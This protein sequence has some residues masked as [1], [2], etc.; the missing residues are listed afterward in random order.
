MVLK[1]GERLR[2]PKCGGKRFNATAHVTQDWELDE[3]G[4]FKKSLN[5]C[6][7]VTHSPDHDDIWDCVKCGFSAPGR[8]FI[9]GSTEEKPARLIESRVA[10][11]VY[12]IS[13]MA[14]HMIEE[15]RIVVDD[16]RGLFNFVYER[17][18]EFETAWAKYEIEGDYMEKI[19][20]F[21]KE[22]LLDAYGRENELKPKV[23]TVSPVVIA[24]RMIEDLGNGD[25]E[26]GDRWSSYFEL[27]RGVGEDFKGQVVAALGEEKHNLPENEWGYCLH[28]INGVDETDCE[29]YHTDHLSESELV[30][31]LADLMKKMERGEL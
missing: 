4:T 31:L 25:S 12:D 29:L 26:N 23:L 15:H 10:E 6:V 21:A 9:T 28:I 8:E 11:C 18:K 3:F 19:E 24:R 13:L 1:E 14:Q 20:E 30:N 5:D 7:E 17:A 2:C 27:A 22:K 16:S